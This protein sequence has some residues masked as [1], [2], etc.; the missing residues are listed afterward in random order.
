MTRPLDHFWINL[1]LRHP[2]CDPSLF[3]TMLGMQP[4]FSAKAGQQLG[5]VLQKSTVW[6]FR[7]PN[8]HGEKAFEQSLNDFSTLLKSHSEFF[9][10]ITADE[11]EILF[12]FNQNIAW[13]DGILFR[14]QLY[15]SFLSVL[16]DYSVGVKVQAWSADDANTESQGSSS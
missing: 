2:Q 5:P 11:G 6:M 12:G 7:F 13:D 1:E 16:T 3:T 9:K 8:Q 4:Y 15:P 14:I 10:K